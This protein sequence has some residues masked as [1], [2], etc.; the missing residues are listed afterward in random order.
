M[1][2]KPGYNPLSR[3]S[4]RSVGY[5]QACHLPDVP[6]RPPLSVAF[7][8]IPPPPFRGPVPPVPRR[9]PW[10]HRPEEPKE[11]RP[12]TP[13]K[14]RAPPAMP[15]SI[16]R[17]PDEAAVTGWFSARTGLEGS[18]R[19]PRRVFRGMRSGLEGSVQSP[20]G[21]GCAG[22]RLILASAKGCATDPLEVVAFL[23]ISL[24]PNLKEGAAKTPA[25]TLLLLTCLFAGDGLS[26]LTL[27]P[28]MP[29][30]KRRGFGKDE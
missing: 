8:P 7:Q 26:R 5:N 17:R 20:L 16:A 29:R 6:N 23:L 28:W 9:W 13:P 2:S 3:D 22:A 19:D 15:K 4:L 12:Q 14:A 27:A 10:F 21:N 25:D 30:S 24:Q 11:S 1:V 18:V